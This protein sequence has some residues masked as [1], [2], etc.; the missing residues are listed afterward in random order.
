MTKLY[1]HARV[2]EEALADMQRVINSKQSIAEIALTRM[3]AP[4]LSTSEEALAL[5]I[6]EL[7][8][9]ISLMKYSTASKPVQ[10]QPKVQKQESAPQKAAVA[11][12]SE[13]L[14][15]TDEF[16]QYGAWH[17]FSIKHQEESRINQC[18]SCF[19]LSKHNNEHRYANQ[20]KRHD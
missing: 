3:C 20:R 5:R 18:R 1:Y 12:K 17:S 11:A 13:P 8:K 9:K 16:K 14:K 19:S 2:L 10:E 7:E 6:E 4:T 15:K